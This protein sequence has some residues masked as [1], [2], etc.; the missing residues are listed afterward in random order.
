MTPGERRIVDFLTVSNA[1]TMAELPDW[2]LALV[3]G[4]GGDG[5]SP[6]LVTA[7]SFLWVRR[8][9]PGIAFSTA[10]QFLASDADDPAKFEEWRMKIQAFRLSC[11]FE[12]L[13][14]AGLFEDVLLGDPFDLDGPVSV[15]LSEEDRAFFNGNPTKQDIHIRMQRRHGLN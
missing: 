3:E 15:V 1:S 2:F 11:G 10:Q 8:E 9:H 6:E 14:R 4:D 12:R 5:W 13:K 7:A